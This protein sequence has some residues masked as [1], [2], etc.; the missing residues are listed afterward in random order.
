MI[1][2]IGDWK[3]QE[4]DER[5]QV[6]RVPSD[7]VVDDGGDEIGGAV[8]ID[9]DRQRN[10]GSFDVE[11]PFPGGN[12]QDRPQATAIEHEADHRSQNRWEKEA[13][14]GEI[15]IDAR[16]RELLSYG[17]KP[18]QFSG[19]LISGN[20]IR[21]ILLSEINVLASKLPVPYD[22]SCPLSEAGIA[23]GLFF[24]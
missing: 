16:R 2:R 15:D 12:Q 4:R 18:G 24:R 1:T 9:R 17:G 13:K 11:A 14:N 6:W 20:H 22:A 10:H 23:A 8:G 5:D 19:S 3:K 7:R 21:Q